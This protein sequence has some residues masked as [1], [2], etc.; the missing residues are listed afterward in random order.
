MAS[1]LASLAD[2]EAPNGALDFAVEVGDS[3]MSHRRRYTVNTSRETV[4]DLLALDTM[5]PRSIIYHLA[6]IKQQVELL[7]HSTHGPMSEL[8][9]A[10]LRV[11]T[12]IA[13]RTPE[14]F[15]TEALLA[16]YDDIAELSDLLTETY[17]K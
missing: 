1:L 8:S 16:C 2:D 12:G 7:P 10:I 13:V 15:D 5:N 3:A 11:H 14:N 6:E 17:L 9:R 4:V